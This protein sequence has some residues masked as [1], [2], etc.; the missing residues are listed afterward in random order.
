VLNFVN[1]TPNAIGYAEVYG[2][3]AADPQ[4][5]VLYID[6]AAP[7]PANVRNGSYKFWTGEHLY[8]STHPSALTSDFLAFLPNYIASSPPS[9]FIACPDAVN[10]AGAGC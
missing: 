3:L 10:I 7:T 8:A 4:V 2:A 6:N 9:D 1:A 5:S